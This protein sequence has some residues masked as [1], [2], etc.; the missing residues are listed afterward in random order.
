[1]VVG[2]ILYS[3]DGQHN[4]SVEIKYPY[5]LEISEDVTKKQFSAH[6]S[7]PDENES[8]I[9]EIIENDWIILS[10][11]KKTKV[12]GYDILFLV[13]QIK[14]KI[15]LDRLKSQL[16]K[17]FQL[18]LQRE[19][20]SRPDYIIDNFNSFFPED[21][22]KKVSLIGRAGTGK[23]SLKK[24]IFEGKNPLNYIL[25]P[26]EPTRGV[27]PSVYSWL[28]LNLGLF[29]S[30]GQELQTIFTDDYT[31]AV[32]FDKADLVIYVAEYPEWVIHKQDLIR[33]IEHV[34]QIIKQ[35]EYSARLIV[36]INKID[37]IKEPSKES[38]LTMIRQEIKEVLGL[39][40]FFTSIHPD[41]VS[42]THETFSSILGSFSWDAR[43]M[44]YIL[45]TEIKTLQRTSLSIS[46]KY[47]AIVAQSSTKDFDFSL[48]NPV[49]GLSIQFATAV[50]DRLPKDN[51]RDLFLKSMEKITIVMKNVEL[52]DTS[53][54][55]VICFSQTMS[56]D[57]LLK[58]A[59]NVKKKLRG[60]YLKRKDQ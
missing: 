33:E 41:S 10:C 45:D 15:I 1:M 47:N 58:A 3:W 32:I 7:D 5:Y 49:H 24:V 46:N 39:D 11:S 14:E 44:K 50:Q 28:D 9:R 4:P 23:T 53:L 22:E 25:N 56:H 48:L 18:V 31:Q 35:H 37:L 42:I 16:R 30:S 40:A 54:M 36:F 13:I 20:K 26:V 6:S 57:I 60:R 29:D 52:L 59:D 8:D 51:I 12:K 34:E 38:I 43:F 19:R 17:F 27:E 21:T 2:I 55:H